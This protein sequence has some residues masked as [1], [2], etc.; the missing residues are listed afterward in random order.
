MAG[1][2]WTWLRP[3]ASA[4]APAEGR[5]R[6]EPPRRARLGGSSRGETEGG[7]GRAAGGDATP[8]LG[9]LAAPATE[10][11]EGAEQRR[12]AP[13][14]RAPPPPPRARARAR[15]RA[16][17]EGRRARARSPAASRKASE[18]RAPPTPNRKRAPAPAAPTN[19]YT[20]CR[21]RGRATFS[22][23]PPTAARLASRCEGGA[24]HLKPWASLTQRESWK[25]H[26]PALWFPPREGQPEARAHLETSWGG[27]AFCARA[28]AGPVAGGPVARARV[29][30]RTPL[31][32]VT[33]RRVRRPGAGGLHLPLLP[34]VW[35]A[36]A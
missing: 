13:Q 32:D 14:P 12:Q 5:P 20:P 25:A 27:W 34:A 4:Q 10:G 8:S 24:G 1:G 17:R 23:I 28:G 11:A 36:A 31:G 7:T 33:C 26:A 35:D 29:E 30:A 22:K 2:R 19:R 21:A 18:A 6:L 9:A 15:T 16:G 3:G